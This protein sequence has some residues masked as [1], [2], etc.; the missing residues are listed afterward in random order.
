MTQ[1]MIVGMP[2]QAEFY[3]LLGE[4]KIHNYMLI[5]SA[6]LINSELMLFLE[7]L[8]VPFTRFSDFKSNPTYKNICD[9]I[10]IYRRLKCDG[11]IALGGGSAIDVAKCVK[12]YGNEALVDDYLN[13]SEFHYN[14]P[15]IAIPTT[16]GTGS[17]S[18]RFAVIYKNGE[19]LSINHESILPTTVVLIPEILKTLPEFQRKCTLMDA[20]AQAIEAWWSVNSTKESKHYSQ[21]AIRLIVDNWKQYIYGEK[22]VY[23]EIIL[24]SNYAGKAINISQTTAPHA[25]SYKLTSLYQLP[26]G[27]AVAICLPKVWK[28]MYYHFSQCADLRGKEYVEN[29]FNDIAHVLGTNDV[30][31]A[32]TFLEELIEELGLKKPIAHE[33]VDLD[34]LSK[35]VN[36][37]RLKNNPIHIDTKG[38]RE[39]YGEIVSF[40]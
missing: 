8:E 39:L 29:T 38:L 23:E 18:T 32:V 26:H 34:L 35:S 10:D 13:I 36:E 37:I 1:K 5:C 6:S 31:S 27:Y 24:A 3:E 17:E 20:L 15:L 25:M 14:V 2:N 30:M 28:Y 16:A 33:G 4:L 40:V 7:N 19:K 22:D 21:Q 12:L 11:I 9:G